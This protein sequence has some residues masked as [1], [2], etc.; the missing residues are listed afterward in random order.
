MS[1]WTAVVAIVAIVSAAGVISSFFSNKSRASIKNTMDK[2]EGEALRKEI[3]EL[4]QRIESLETIVTDSSFDL[5][6]QFDKL[7]DDNVA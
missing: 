3:F 1:F 4:K 6:R 5:K 2:V 7:D